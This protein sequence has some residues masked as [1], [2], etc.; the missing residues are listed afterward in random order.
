MYYNNF[1]FH[2][3]KEKEYVFMKHDLPSSVDLTCSLL[4]GTTWGKWF[5]EDKGGEMKNSP[6]IPLCA[7]SLRIEMPG[8]IFRYYV[9]R[10]I[11]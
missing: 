1:T 2:F 8:L 11:I 9:I 10:I 5:W 6:P 7:V 3:H 4:P